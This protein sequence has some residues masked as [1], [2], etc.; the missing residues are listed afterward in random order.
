MSDARH[1]EKHGLCAFLMALLKGLAVLWLATDLLL[2]DMCYVQVVAQAIGLWLHHMLYPEEPDNGVAPPP[3]DTYGEGMWGWCKHAFQTEKRPLWL[4]LRRLATLVV[5]YFAHSVF[6]TKAMIAQMDDFCGAL[7]RSEVPDISAQMVEG[8]MIFLVALGACFQ[9]LLPSTVHTR[10][11]E[12]LNAVAFAAKRAA[13]KRNAS[14][15]ETKR[16]A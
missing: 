2:D 13:E 11:R 12:N 5:I 15:H 4:I 7:R 14:T 10:S 8:H 9:F 1:P 6:L 16:A 3:R